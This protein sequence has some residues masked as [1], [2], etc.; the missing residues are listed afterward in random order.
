MKLPA[1]IVFIT[2]G[3]ISTL[4]RSYIVVFEKM[5]VNF[6]KRKAYN[7]IIGVNFAAIHTI[8]KGDHV[9][10]DLFS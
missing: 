5:A 4:T 3:W 1:L 8:L 9:L 10:S 2:L 6:G 7:A